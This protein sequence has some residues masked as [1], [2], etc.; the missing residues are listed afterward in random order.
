LN[1]PRNFTEIAIKDSWGVCSF[2]LQRFLL[3]GSS[4]NGFEERKEKEKK[5]KKLL[6]K[7]KR[8]LLPPLSPSLKFSSGFVFQLHHGNGSD[9]GA[10]LGGNGSVCHVQGISQQSKRER[11]GAVRRRRSCR[12]HETRSRPATTMVCITFIRW[13][14]PFLSLHIQPPPAFLPL[15]L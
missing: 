5:R 11:H 14:W 8:I 1:F 3:K 2:S 9:E 7:R 13:R 10:I 6:M 12:R 4:E 15:R